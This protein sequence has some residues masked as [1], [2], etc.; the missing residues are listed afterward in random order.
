MKIKSKK[1]SH[2]MLGDPDFE[3]S[4]IT[5]K[6]LLDLDDLGGDTSMFEKFKFMEVIQRKYTGES[7]DNMLIWFKGCR[8]NT[9]TKHS[10][11]KKKLFIVELINN[12]LKNQDTLL[13][14]DD[15][16]IGTEHEN[17]VI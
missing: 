4:E 9:F 15:K 7:G 5:W 11:D 3:H 16:W 12:Y 8:T 14:L 17:V 2:E 1:I 10:P 6:I 13:S